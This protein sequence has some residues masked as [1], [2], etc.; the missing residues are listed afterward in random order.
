MM[1]AFPLLLLLVYF[2]KGTTI[3]R[4][5]SGDPTP[6]LIRL[7][8]RTTDDQDPDLLRGTPTPAV[9]TYVRAQSVSVPNN[10]D[11]SVDKVVENGKVSLRGRSS[12]YFP[13][14]QYKVKPDDKDIPSY[15][16]AGPSA[17][18]TLIRDPVLY[19]LVAAG[20]AWAPV[21]TPVALYRATNDDPLTYHGLYYRKDKVGYL[22]G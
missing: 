13:K 15:I 16:L 14:K 2:S 3:A 6:S 20:E 11:V 7:L 10:S 5:V 12:R 21:V 9:L 19:Q 1:L 22:K 8:L 18:F 17:D 4:E